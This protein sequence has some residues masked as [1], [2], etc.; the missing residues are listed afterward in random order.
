MV[1]ARLDW[2]VAMLRRR[3]GSAL[4]SLRPR[5]PGAARWA[6]APAFLAALNSARVEVLREDAQQKAMAYTASK[7]LM[8]LRVAM[9]Q[10][11][12]GS[13]GVRCASPPVFFSQPNPPAVER[14]PTFILS[15]VL[16]SDFW[17][18]N[19]AAVKSANAKLPILVR[20]ASGTPATLTA[21]YEFG[22]E[23][24]VAVDGMSADA[25]GKELSTLM[26]G[27]GS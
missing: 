21:A 17:A 16:R 13:A 26:S 6:C 14:S 8:E 1:S 15:L 20:E 9:C 23:K 2:R 27:T 19:Y 7:A 25:F 11:G 22:V 18:K 12:A 24:T 3:R 10:T 4:C 5:P